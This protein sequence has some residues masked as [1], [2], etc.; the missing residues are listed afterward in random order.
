[1]S[2]FL[3]ILNGSEPIF[4]TVVIVFSLIIGSFLNVIIFRLPIILQKGWRQQCYEFLE[5]KVPVTE[6]PD[7]MQSQVLLIELF[8][9]P[10]H[11]LHCNTPIKFYDNVPLLS[12]IILRGK[13]RSCKHKFSIQYPIIEALAAALAAAVALRFSVSWQTVAGCILSYV[14][15]VQAAID[16]RH[17]II[18]DEVTL[19]A[20]W[21][22]LLLSIQFVFV[23]S[24]DA[25]IGAVA[26]YMF[27]WLVYWSF[28]WATKKEGMGYG[29]FKLLAMIG[30]WLGWQMLPFTILCSSIIG[31]VIGVGLIFLHKKKRVKR[32]P[33]GPFLSMAGWIA[34]I[35]GND[36]NTW[37]LQFAGLM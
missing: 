14:L 37:Y 35:C 13:C 34:M 16:L 36:I 19:P 15:I 2:D 7:L 28:F 10:S 21:I 3:T 11:C 9:R 31:S 6:Q 27:L 25:I 17:T 26:G 23:N 24:T 30:A 8:T 22:G 32:I 18:P 1:M 33:F 12:Y 5:T 29:D 4:L 20:L